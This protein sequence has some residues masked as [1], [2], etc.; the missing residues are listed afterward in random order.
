MWSLRIILLFTNV[1]RLMKQYKSA[2]T[3]Y[4]RFLILPCTVLK[5]LLEFATKKTQF[6]FYD[7]YYEQTDVVAMSSLVNPVLANI[8]MRYF[9]EK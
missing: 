3:S 2:L 6:N 1:C 7:K 4:I 5:T 8:F 9:E